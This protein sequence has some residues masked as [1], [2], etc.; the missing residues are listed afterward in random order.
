MDALAPHMC[1]LSLVLWGTLALGNPATLGLSLSYLDSSHELKRAS[2]FLPY[3]EIS[4]TQRLPEECHLITGKITGSASW[5]VSSCKW[6]NHRN[7]HL[8]QWIFIL[9]NSETSISLSVNSKSYNMKSSK[10]IFFFNHSLL[11]MDFVDSHILDFISHFPALC[12]FRSR[13][14]KERTS[15]LVSASSIREKAKQKQKQIKKG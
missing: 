11:D 6:G 9:R 1:K 8:S 5:N 3:L 14:S 2:S 7:L 15:E 4:K 10:K 13:H 12:I